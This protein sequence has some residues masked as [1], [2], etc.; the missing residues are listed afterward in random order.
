MKRMIAFMIA[1]V[2]CIPILAGCGE[3]EK[4]TP[5][6][7]DGKLTIGIPDN[8]M[9]IDYETNAYTLW[10][11]EQTGIDLEF[12]VF[13]A[14]SA[15]A[16]SQLATMVAG[17]E[18]LPDVIIGLGLGSK[19]IKDYG[20]DRYFLDLKDYLY[21]KEKSANF[22]ELFEEMYPNEEDQKVQLARI[23]DPENG[24]IYAFP[25]MEYSLF[26]TI[27]S[28]VYINKTWLDKLGLEMPN[29]NESLRK[30]LDAFVNKDPNGNGKKD[31]IGIVGRPYGSTGHSAISWILNNFCL[32]SNN[33]WFNV[34]DKGKLSLP[35]ASD[36]Y[37]QALIYLNE[38]TRDG[39]LTNSIWNMD[40]GDTKKLLSP[41]DGVNTVGI[42]VGH[43]SSVL[44]E[45]Y[46]NH[47]E[48]EPLPYWGY[49][50]ENEQTLSK[51]VYITEDCSNVDAAWKLIMAM[52]TKEAGYRTR[53]GEF[54]VD[55][56]YA[57]EGTKSFL[58]L[59]AEIKVLNASQWSTMN[60]SN[61]HRTYGTILTFSENEATQM[62]D[63]TDQ[64]ATNKYRLMRGTYNNF[65]AALKAKPYNKMIDLIYT[66][67]ERMA[68]EAE[69]TNCK[70]WITTMM[71]Q[72]ACGTDGHNPADDADWQKYINEL[73]R[74][75]VDT[76]LKQAQQIY[77]R[78]TK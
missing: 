27:D 7:W 13:A 15:D 39:L 63:D 52:N 17:G 14:S 55:W 21:D 47:Y 53:Y 74:L 8:S 43:P 58:D 44:Q 16:K 30:V 5:G 19:E 48:Y 1:V 77:D 76:W 42:F 78:Q 38:L 68:T 25:S 24:A 57:D 20:D 45:G 70:A 50:V 29:S 9:V 41:A 22:W 40:A 35:F 72:F 12:H 33:Q 36:E 60:N 67:K 11:E 71:A 69:L 49:A 51:V 34:D 56:D 75:G 31:E 64:W 61:W 4:K 28:M 73:D 2:L 10:L 3:K 59:D 46:V 62:P 23:T 18:K 65:Q 26:D 32:V 66:D 6:D 54:G 37:R